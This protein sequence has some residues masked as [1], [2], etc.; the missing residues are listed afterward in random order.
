MRGA[1]G[2]PEGASL[3]N[4]VRMIHANLSSEV[5]KAGPGTLCHPHHTTVLVAPNLAC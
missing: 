1:L 3:T 4:V 5:W 2:I